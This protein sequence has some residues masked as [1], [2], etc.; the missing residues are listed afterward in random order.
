MNYFVIVKA[1][2]IIVH[3]ERINKNVLQ[4]AFAKIAKINDL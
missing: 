2:L 3:V 4:D 1:V